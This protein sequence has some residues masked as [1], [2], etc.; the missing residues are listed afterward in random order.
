MQGHKAPTSWQGLQVAE[1]WGRQGQQEAKPRKRRTNGSAPAQTRTRTNPNKGASHRPSGREKGRGEDHT[2]DRS[3]PQSAKRKAHA[4]RTPE[5]KEREGEEGEE[6][7]VI[8]YGTADGILYLCKVFLAFAG[9]LDFGGQGQGHRARARA[10]PG[11]GPGP[12]LGP[13]Q[14]QG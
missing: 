5:K 9:I 8:M 13:G 11:P 3:G 10:G 1:P 7:E 4:E 14:G 12:G 6:D 2:I